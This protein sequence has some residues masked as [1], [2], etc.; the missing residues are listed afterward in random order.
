[1][2][3]DCGQVCR[4]GMGGPHTAAGVAV[5]FVLYN[6]CRVREVRIPATWLNASTLLRLHVGDACEAE[7]RA[8]A[9]CIAEC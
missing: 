9:W 1:M 4:R 3:R 2:G 6:P 8:A 7:R 5:L